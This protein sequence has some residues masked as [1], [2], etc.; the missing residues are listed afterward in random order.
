MSCFDNCNNR[1]FCFEGSC[2]CEPGYSG[3][4]IIGNS[5]VV[6]CGDT[7]DEKYTVAFAFLRWL[8]ELAPSAAFLILWLMLLPFVIARRRRSSAAVNLSAEASEHAGTE[9]HEATQLKLAAQNFDI[10]VVVLFIALLTVNIVAWSV[11]PYGYSEWF[12]FGL[13]LVLRDYCAIQPVIYQSA[14]FVGWHCFNRSVA[15]RV[16]AEE[17]TTE[18]GY[19]GE[20]ITMQQLWLALQI[21]VVGGQVLCTALHINQSSRYF[22]YTLAFNGFIALILL[23][24]IPLPWVVGSHTLKL[25]PNDIASQQRGIMLK[26]MGLFLV[27]FLTFTIPVVVEATV[28]DWLVPIFLSPITIT[29][30][31]AGVAIPF[32]IFFQTI[33]IDEVQNWRN[34]Y[35]DASS[36][37][38]SDSDSSDA[39]RSEVELESQASA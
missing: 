30:K 34:N 21:L 16:K 20:S 29:G 33:F 26:L 4:R 13:F 6:T 1:G 9:H 28:S 22:G 18:R 15:R 12:P 2:I 37:S 36:G 25:L 35:S 7:Y 38:S 39:D 19:I 23:S 24:M 8:G 11:N 17:N 10:V 14:I 32:A 31:F 5:T 3:T 27:G